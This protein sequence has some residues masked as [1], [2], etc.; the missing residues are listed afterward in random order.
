MT[1]FRFCLTF[2]TWRVRKENIFAL[3][4]AC[5]RRRRARHHICIITSETEVRLGNQKTGESLTLT[6]VGEIDPDTDGHFLLRRSCLVG[7]LEQSYFD[8]ISNDDKKCIKFNDYCSLYSTWRPW[9]KAI[10]T[11]GYKVRGNE[12]S[13]QLVSTYICFLF[14]VEFLL[15]LANLL[16]IAVACQQAFCLPIFAVI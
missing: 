16:L 10:K 1:P 3:L 11:V 7:P 4:S 9:K 14:A 2:K 5:D 13:T 15:L 6:S 12:L 8:R